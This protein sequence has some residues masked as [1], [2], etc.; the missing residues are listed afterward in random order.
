MTASAVAYLSVPLKKTWE[1]EL[2]KPLRNFIAD[3]YSECSPE[4]QKTSLNEFQKL[5]NNAI[6]KSVDKH[7][8]ALEILYRYYDQ[9]VAIETKFPMTENQIRI[10]FKWQD[11]FNKES[12]FSGKRALTIANG[13]FERVCILFN[14]AALQ[15]QIAAAQNMNSDDGLKTTAK[16]FQQSSGIFAHL[17]AVSLSS[18]QND[19]TPDLH[20]DTL[21]ALGA[22][23]LAQAQDSIVRKA[24]NDKMKPGVVAKLALQCS[25]LYADAMKLLGLESIKS[26]WP[27][28]WL[29]SV[30]GRQAAF[31]GIAQYQQ[32]LVSK[33][34]K[35]FGE[36]IARLR[37]SKDL[38][39]A[40]ESRGSQTFAFK[41]VQKIVL[42][43]L[44][45]AEKD[46]NFIY[47]A[48]IPELTSLSSIG[49]AAVAKSTPPSRPLS[50]NFKDLFEKIVPLSVHLALMAF[51]NRKSEIVNMEI[52]R[53]REATQLLNGVFASLNLPAAI[54]DVSGGSQVPQSVLEK[55]EK[56]R[57]AGGYEQ[58][59]K[60]IN[61]LPASL[62]RNKEILDECDNLLN[63]EASSDQQLR[64]QFKDRWTR[65][66]SAQLTEPMRTES[67]K[68]RQIISNAISADAVVRSRFGAQK[69]GIELLSKS[70]GDI[71]GC[72]P[73]A[74]PV[75]ALQGNPAVSE[76]RRLLSEVEGIKST[77]DRLETQLKDIGCD[78][79]ESK[80]LS[81][82][83][84]DG[85]LNE[86]DISTN[87]LDSVFAPIRSHI[88]DNIKMQETL[89]GQI[90]AANTKFVEAKAQYDSG[91]AREEKL[92]IL[93]TAFDS[94]VE[95]KGNLE[96]GSKF[97]NDLTQILVK[98]QSKVA[99][100]C[101]ARKTEK[102]ELMKDLSTSIAR[103]PTSQP[104]A[105]PNYQKPPVAA[106]RSSPAAS[107]TPAAPAMSESV[108]FY[109]GYPTSAP[110]SSYPSSMPM[111]TGYNPYTAYPAQQFGPGYLPAAYPQPQPG[112]QVPT[113]YPAQPGYPAQGYL[114][115][116]PGYTGYPQQYPGY[117]PR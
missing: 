24:M 36:E 26:L 88:I 39:T 85:A 5:R 3:T 76:L 43:A 23:M 38:L 83:S 10:N 87:H 33:E 107:C 8:S 44:Q 6:A 37:H 16:L 14:I 64:D 41:D 34:A 78:D 72:I 73:S 19:P 117:P 2:A 104:P 60:L 109:P 54:E 81:A 20:P 75:A 1:V 93:A 40:A 42:R 86:E 21:N 49:K 105:V 52:S 55:A 32:S 115:Q 103:Q 111:P 116:Q 22:L 92:K 57:Q 68:Y 69:E 77:R 4:D 62:E 17:Q 94:F 101:F 110:T 74:S 7:E 114:P 84:Q 45:D 48:K 82:L 70:N 99:D 50:S 98:F 31:H 97:Y 11:A 53:L 35:D 102:E 56:I 89:L 46:N 95:L 63:E 51:N 18:V 65:T 15:S 47:H 66:A 28:D 96:E 61:D 91:A 67:S 30:S 9:L 113:A 106:P 29:N 80:F 112:Y 58:I 100:F 13:S 90:Q 12:L 79:I 25:D 27:K 59:L 71:E 108:P